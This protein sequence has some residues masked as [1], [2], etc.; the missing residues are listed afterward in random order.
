MT[1]FE[2]VVL[3]SDILVWLLVAAGVAIGVFVARDPPLLSAWRR[4]GANRVGMASATVLLAFIAIGLL[5]SLHYRVALEGKP[6]QKTQ[7]AVEVLSLLD[8]L[9]APLRMRNEKTYSEPFATRLYAR[10]TIDVPGQ[11]TVRDYPRLKHGGK[12]LGEREDAVAADAGFTAL[13]MAALAFVAWFGIAA[14]ASA[15]VAR[16]AAAVDRPGWQKIRRGE[17]AFAW[18]AV[19]TTLL[20]MLLVAVPLFALAGR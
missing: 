4:V 16:G 7:Y 8:A 10:E 9:A 5:D 11:G 17:T 14:L 3:W 12:H 18:D 15:A 19:L 2:I 13:R 1:G 20:V 6:G